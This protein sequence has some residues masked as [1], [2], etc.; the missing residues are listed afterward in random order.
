M[1]LGFVGVGFIVAAIIQVI[2]LLPYLGSLANTSSITKNLMQLM[3]D[4]TKANL[5]RWMQLASACVMFFV[6][7]LITALLISKSAFKYLGFNTIISFR[8]VLLVIGIAMLALVFSTVL[9]ELNSALPIPPSWAAR[10]KSM[11]ETYNSQVMAIAKM[12]SFGEYLFVMI[13]IALAP[14]IF[15]EALFRAGLQQTLTN[16]TK[17]PITAIIITSIL[18]SAVHMSF[19]GF[20]PRAALGVVLGLIFY[21]SKNIWLSILMHFLNNGISITAFYWLTKNGKPAKEALEPNLSNQMTHVGTAITG[22]LVLTLLTFLLQRFKS[23]SEQL[24]TEDS[25]KYLKTINNPFG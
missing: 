2:M 14:A 15:E 5:M 3:N 10:F 12:N 21:Y 16:W 7:V 17:R 19:Y 20:L 1:I 23:A 8:Q 11:E 18:F 24:P 22:M 4:P 9:G 6:P 25:S 13:V